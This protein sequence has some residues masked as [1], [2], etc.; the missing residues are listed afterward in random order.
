[1][2]RE[3]VTLFEV[4]KFDTRTLEERERGADWSA[5]GGL[6]G[7]SYMVLATVPD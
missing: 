7:T 4:S 6:Y 1:M 2:R 3:R 5:A